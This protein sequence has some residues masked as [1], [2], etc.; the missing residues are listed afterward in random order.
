MKG[1]F[2]RDTFD[3]RRQFTRVLMQQGRVLLDAD[4]NEQA[5]ILLHYLQTLA[6]DLIGPAGGPFANLGF[7]IEP[8]LTGTPPRLNDLTIGPGRYYVDGILCEL[9]TE[10]TYREQPDWVGH[11]FDEPVRLPL[12]VVLDVW[13]RHLI[14]LEEPRIREV[15]LGGPDTATRARIMRQV[16]I[17]E[18]PESTPPDDL[19]CL[20]FDQS[21]A[22]VELKNRLQPANR[23]LL[24]ANAK[25]ERE[26]ATNPCI[27]SPDARFRGAENH[28]YRVEIHKG[29]TAGTA[30][31]KW[32]REN[33]SVVFAV[34]SIQGKIVT[35]ESLGRDARLG[36]EAGDWIEI[37]DTESDSGS[38]RVPAPLLLVEK[39]DLIG[40]TLTLGGTP[41]VDP[42]RVLYLRR[43]DQRAGDPSKDGLTLVDGAAKIVE[44]SPLNLEDG[45]QIR[46]EPGGN[47]RRG[48]FWLIPARTATGD[49]EWP[50]RDGNPIPLP[51][52]GVEHHYAPLAVV[53]ADGANVEV[54]DLRHSMSPLATCC[55]TVKVVNPPSSPRATPIEFRA[56]ADRDH[57]SLS[58]TWHV[59][60]GTIEPG[61]TDP[62]VIRVKAEPAPVDH[63]TATVGVQG[64]SKGCVAFASGTC[65]IV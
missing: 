11:E 31:F 10:T 63:V 32:S 6:A 58:F 4:W 54:N 20:E 53:V 37:I 40:L 52:Q 28:L 5:S 45:I 50:E 36:L 55:P 42:A 43:W 57:R 44:S 14:H 23:G 8:V 2:S 61:G 13:E 21:P 24:S 48:D 3:R 17:F 62:A 56:I 34:E 22:W 19:E 16:R 41:V 12:L 38:E 30:T 35:L 65:V 25:E 15:A 49:V 46:F 39:I 1:D 64:P 29:G 26:D 27:V 60:G 51:P 47:Y 59:D 33:G 9:D 18:L 7:S